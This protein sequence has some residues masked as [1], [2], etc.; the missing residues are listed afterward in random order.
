MGSRRLTIERFE[1]VIKEETFTSVLDLALEALNSR[2]VR[3]GLG[4]SK[5]SKKNSRVSITRATFKED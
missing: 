2:F 3:L 4:F 1:R 5:K